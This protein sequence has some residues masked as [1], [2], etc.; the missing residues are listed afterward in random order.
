MGEVELGAGWGAVVDG[1]TVDGAK[2][3]AE[4]EEGEEEE[5]EDDDDDEEDEGFPRL[6]ESD[7]CGEGEA[8]A[9]EGE[10]QVENLWALAESGVFAR[11]G[12]ESDWEASAQ[13]VGEVS[14]LEAVE[15]V[16]GFFEER[17]PGSH[18]ERR[19]T[20]IRWAYGAADAEL[21]SQQV[22]PF[23]PR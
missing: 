20:T 21:G 10:A 7:A 16:F 17:T 8:E 19:D 4:G 12:R 11:R 1:D 23:G 15:E 18:V 9:T 13:V 3:A 2:G 6:R 22:P 5:D 14:W